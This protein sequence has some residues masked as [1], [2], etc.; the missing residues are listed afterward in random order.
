MFP[1][2]TLSPCLLSVAPNVTI[3]KSLVHSSENFDAQ[4][5]CNVLAE[6]Q[7]S[8]STSIS[9]QCTDPSN[10]RVQLI[11]WGRYILQNEMR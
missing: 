2:L 3:E 6:P 10:I 11:H 1:C 7:A 9:L 8:V 5:V 4:L